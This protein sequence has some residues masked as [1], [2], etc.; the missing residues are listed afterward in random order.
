MAIGSALSMLG[1]YP[2][3]DSLKSCQIH[4]KKVQAILKAKGSRTHQILTFI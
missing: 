3:I 1:Y 4:A 2:N